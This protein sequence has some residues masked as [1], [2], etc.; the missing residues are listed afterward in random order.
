MKRAAAALFLATGLAAVSFGA[1]PAPAPVAAVAAAIGLVVWGAVAG[2]PERWGARIAYGLLIAYLGIWAWTAFDTWRVTMAGPG[3]AARLESEARAGVARALSARLAEDRELAETTARRLASGGSLPLPDEESEWFVSLGRA[4][5]ERLSEGIGLELYDSEGALRAWWGDPRGERLPPDSIAAALAGG[6]VRNPTG[7]VIAYV[8]KPQTIGR[9]TFRVVVKDLWAVESPL[10]REALEP[11]L[12]LARL[13]RE[14]HLAFR[15]LPGGDTL[16]PSERSS[17]VGG[18]REVV[19]G[20]ASEG[21]LLQRYVA[22]RRRQGE[23]AMALLLLW[24]LAWAVGVGWEASRRTARVVPRIG[25]GG[26]G[27]AIA[28]LLVR[29]G[30]VA[31]VWALLVESRLPARLLPEEWF[32]PLGFAAPAFGPAGRSAGHLLVTAAATAIMAWTAWSLLVTRREGRRRPVVATL[33]VVVALAVTW[34]LGRLAVPSLEGALEGMSPAAFFSPTLL[35]AP[36]L[37]LVLL[38][39]ALFG[40]AVVVALAGVLRWAGTPD[41]PAWGGGAALVVGAA[42]GIAAWRLPEAS[43]AGHPVEVVAPSAIA[44]VAGAWATLAVGR[45]RGARRVRLV[46]L[47][48]VATAVGALATLP[49]AAFA[50]V[51]A[52]H[53]LLV[54]RAQRIGEASSQWLDYTMTRTVEFLANEPAV[55]E[56]IAEENRDAALALWSRSPLRELDFATGLF[57]FDAE[58]RVVSQFS[59]AP[60]DLTDRARRYVAALE[61]AQIPVRGSQGTGAVRWAVV[62]VLDAAGRRNGTAVAMTTGSVELRE[63]GTGF[64]LTD[65]LAGGGIEPDVPGYTTLGPEEEP[66]PRTLLTRVRAF[67]AEGEVG[68]LQLAMPLD[69]LLPGPRGTAV[70]VLAAS[71]LALALGLLERAG[72][73]RARTAWRA[74]IAA[75]NPLRSFR[76][77]LVLAFLAVAALPL[78]LYAVLGYRTTRLELEEATRSAASEALNAASR[79]LARDRALAIASDRELS[80]RLREI[81]DVLQQDLVLYWRGHTRASSR[82]EIFA[83]RVFADRIDGSVYATLF[84]ERRPIAF[85]ETTLG[86]RSFLVAYRA[87][88]EPDVPPGYA[89]ATP[90]LIRED[91]VRVDLQRLGEGVFLLSAFSIG[92]LLVVGWGLARFMS[93]PLSALEEGTRHIAAGRLSYRLSTP[94]RRDEFGR[95]QRAFNAMAGRLDASQRALER[96]KS[97]V[98]AILASVGAGVVALDARGGVRLLNDRAAD[99]LDEEAEDVL[100]RSVEELARRERPAAPFWRAVAEASVR[101]ARADRDLVLRREGA[102]RHYHVVC[103]GLVDGAGEERGL[104]VAF[105]DITANVQSQRV[106]AWGEMARQV[107]HE[108]KN[109]LTPMKLSLQH[110]EK[111]VED[112]APDFERLFHRNLDLVLSEIDRLERIA[113]SFARFGVP[114]PTV[115]EPFDAVAVAR[116]A[117]ELF[118]PGDEKI[119]YAL[120]VTGEARPVLGEAEG[121]RRVL[122]NLL[123]NAREAVL[124]TAAR[125][126]RVAVEIDFAGDAEEARVSVVDDGTGLSADATDRLFEPSFSTKT[127]GTGLGLAIVKRTVETWGGSVEWERRRPAGTAIH[128]RLR[129]NGG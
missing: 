40:A 49:L 1:V 67:D 59:L 93:R 111:T 29:L 82:P 17:V 72:D 41:G 22:E 34:G 92:F 36:P 119:D 24:P 128:L 122:V 91:R 46:R 129:T 13:S 48:I 71:A 8:G 28:A 56:A 45:P 100:G 11:D 42:V 96:E 47:A 51:Q 80:A 60:E 26:R 9:D 58:G 86:E 90:L 84:A 20:V 69:P 27:E 6:V 7:W 5:P 33:T 108:I 2:R 99:L 31:L 75:E 39:F 87:L 97:R 25:A 18:S 106:L 74:R 76:A 61:P 120:E 73:P 117:I 114:Q 95:V 50:R 101:G 57:L 118:R 89:L 21:F 32:S 112:R 102:E 104:V 85:D 123:Q 83:S 125:K 105:E 64:V 70:F 124:G 66:P 16:A 107:A 12:I 35:F 121:F 53:E 3:A 77:Q 4:T 30:L 10:R 79:L 37:L 15:L 63:Q 126:G 88:S 113:G 44:I 103:T 98:Q 19:A 109:P 68:T 116:D 115:V 78:T 23:R 43:M 55:S 14:R 94:A 52:A 38:G 54:E 127:R 65:L 62:P 81:G 110:L